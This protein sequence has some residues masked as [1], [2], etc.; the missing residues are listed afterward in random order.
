MIELKIIDYDTIK[1]L[2]NKVSKESVTLENNEHATW[3]GA[4]EHSILVGFTCVVIKGKHA[5]YKSDY[6]FPEHRNKGI[7]AM[8]F[9]FRHNFTVTHGNITHVTA[10]CTKM[11]IGTF[12]LHG[13][14]PMSKNEKN[15]TFVKLN[16]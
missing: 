16:L 13:F 4:F 11:S 10:F 6:V 9:A 8:L 7:Y 5:R 1:S 2:K 12:L 3:F 15:I 14:T